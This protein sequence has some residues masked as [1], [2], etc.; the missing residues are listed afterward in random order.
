MLVEVGLT[1]K[2]HALSQTLSGGMKRKLCLAM[3][4]LG[5][6]QFIL[7]DEPT[8]G[9]DPVSR[10]RTW[11]LLQRCK[12]GR[13]ILLTTHYMDEADILADRVAIMSEGA[14][15][16]VGSPSYLK[17]MFGVGYLLSVSK[18]DPLAS[19]SR[20]SEAIQQIVPEASVHSSV[21]REVIFRLPQST[22]SSFGRLFQML[23]D[24]S[25]E[26]GIASYGFRAPSMEQVFLSLKATSSRDG[27]PAASSLYH[28]YVRRWLSSGYTWLI[29]YVGLILQW[30]ASSDDGDNV[31][32]D[33]GNTVPT[34]RH[35]PPA[36][37]SNE[38]MYGTSNCPHW[39]IQLFELCR[40]RVIVLRGDFQGFLCQIL[41]PAVLIVLI[42][43]ILTVRLNISGSPLPLNANMYHRYGQVVPTILV[44]DTARSPLVPSI[45]A[46]ADSNRFIIETAP[47]QSGI[48]S[49]TLSRFLL[50]DA[51]HDGRKKRTTM[52]SSD[53]HGAFVFPDD[54]LALHVTIDWDWV[55]S[56]LTK[57][58]NLSI[59]STEGAVVFKFSVN[60]TLLPLVSPSFLSQLGRTLPF[61]YLWKNHMNGMVANNS[62]HTSRNHEVF[63]WPYWLAP[64]LASFNVSSAKANLT[65][66]HVENNDLML[67]FHTE[68]DMVTFNLHATEVSIPVTNMTSL[69]PIA[70]AFDATV[71]LSHESISLSSPR[72]RPEVEWTIVIRSRE[73]YSESRDLFLSLLPKGSIQY[74]YNIP[75]KLT[76]LHNTTS[77]HGA[78]ALHGQLVE[79]TFHLCMQ[80][81]QPTT[82]N[83]TALHRSDPDAVSVETANTNNSRS[84]GS[85]LPRYTVENHPLPITAQQSLQ[86]QVILSLLTSLF[87]L[88]PFG[89]LPATCVACLV[90]ERVSKS[91]H[92]QRLS[93]VSMY[94]YWLAA[95]L[96][97]MSL[98]ALLVFFVLG[99]LFV[100]VGHGT[101]VFI[102]S[103]SQTLAFFCLLMC[104]AAAALPFAYL[105]SLIFSHFAT[106]QIAI[107]TM[108]FLTGFV[109]IVA[110]SILSSLLSTQ[111]MTNEILVHV[112][113]LFPGFVV[114][115]GLIHLSIHY[116]EHMVG[117]L[118]DVGTAALDTDEDAAFRGVWHWE[119]VGRDLVFLFMQSVVFMSMVLWSESTHVRRMVDSFMRYWR[120]RCSVDCRDNDGLPCPSPRVTSMDG[121]VKREEELVCKLT[122]QLLKNKHTE[123]P[124]EDELL[125][126]GE[127]HI[128]ECEG[129]GTAAVVLLID[130]L[131]KTYASSICGGLHT[132]AVR[133]LSLIG[134]AHECLGLLGINGAGKTT[135]LE[136]LAGEIQATFGDV[137]ILVD[138]CAAMFQRQMLV[139][140]CPQV[141]PLVDENMNAYETLWFYGRIRGITPGVLHL[142]IQR[143]IAETGLTSQQAQR[144]CGTYSGGNKRKLSLAIALLGDPHVLLL[145]EP[146]A[147]M[148]PA[149][150]RQMW[151]L[152]Q[153]QVQQHPCTVILVGHCMEE[154]EA[155]CSRVGVMVRGRLMCLGTIPHLK[156]TFGVGYQIEVRC[157]VDHVQAC[158][159][160][161][162]D[163]FT[164]N[165]NN[166][167][168]SGQS[169]R[170]L[171]HIHVTV[172]EEPAQKQKEEESHF[173]IED[174]CGGYFRLRE[175][176]GHVVD[177][178][179]AFDVLERNKEALEIYDY[180]ISQGSF[181]QV[182][183]KVVCE[184]SSAC[185]TSS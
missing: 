168:E 28:T 144:P 21:V 2:R 143:L 167:C 4:L 46:Y 19:M 138:G 111:R 176:D 94:V 14:L 134:Y 136:I 152:V 142:R 31:E 60:G 58:K 27:S 38:D 10:Q 72:V 129:G 62:Y 179:M 75:S 174:I 150:R 11:E 61:S 76:L 39:K 147:G 67:S 69:H 68:N 20:M 6:P 177:L 16:C 181:E 80:Q 157:G 98:F 89:S 50:S 37:S 100:L 115:E 47:P 44:P 43:R 124:P 82:Q 78:A 139:G 151:H 130:Q 15:F 175:H 48:N 90:K 162:A 158:L 106:A 114:G 96:W 87:L 59:E 103:S 107:V 40:K 35:F 26:L 112:F 141:D 63:G 104:Y 17:R 36:P 184:P 182:F 51:I 83:T 77:P 125:F 12:M 52:G 163:F 172:A 153:Q 3:A 57:H 25:E 53:R 91:K 128:Q 137:R 66:N 85:R 165:G 102:S 121:D 34:S 55:G 95:F 84:F 116:F 18:S 108:N 109:L 122:N 9:M 127:S 5:D 118:N 154:I 169:N 101:C 71:R 140:Y 93:G 7:L 24:R 81:H 159:A 173:V 166:S 120:R 155:L 171:N 64:L 97:D 1:D 123:E 45:H 117:V 8:S 23:R 161:C 30:P 92:L 119:V 183:L 160:L 131:V 13:V 132:H 79:A 105:C 148:D 170:R 110:Y 133:G 99:S 33:Y 156:D 145:D 178:A 113:R 126:S 41:C 65:V 185:D 54:E 149:A 29:G 88:V 70:T 164:I 56:M 42:L 49:S 74:T 22:L 146:S 73:L 180:S 135:T 32:Q 86:V